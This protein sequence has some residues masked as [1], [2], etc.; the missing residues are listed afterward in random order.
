MSPAKAL[1]TAKTVM[2]F[3]ASK[4]FF[5]SGGGADMILKV[6]EVY[7]FMQYSG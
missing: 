2:S 7:P 4:Q 3:S 5:A 1:I 6:F